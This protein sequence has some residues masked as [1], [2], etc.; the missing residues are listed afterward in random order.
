MFQTF[1][2][3]A[4]EPP[5]ANGM[6]ALLLKWNAQ[7]WEVSAECQCGASQSVGD[8]LIALLETNLPYL[9][10]NKSS[11]CLGERILIPLNLLRLRR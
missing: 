9:L 11:I 1:Q 7:E 2:N 4:K 8:S 6:A 10:D 3:P 5:Q